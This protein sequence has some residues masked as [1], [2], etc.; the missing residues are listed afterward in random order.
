MM[1][2]GADYYRRGADLDAIREAMGPGPN[3]PRYVMRLPGIIIPLP[4]GEEGGRLAESTLKTDVALGA[5]FIAVM[6]LGVLFFLASAIRLA[7]A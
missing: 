4:E 5:V 3:S 7:G 6:L 1:N 2:P